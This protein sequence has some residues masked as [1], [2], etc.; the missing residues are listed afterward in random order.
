MY[1]ACSVT[2]SGVG[3]FY[4]I[5]F[6]QL[7]C[8]CCLFIETSKLLTIFSQ[9][10]ESRLGSAA[11][12]ALNLCRFFTCRLKMGRLFLFFFLLW[13]AYL[14]MT[15]SPIW[16]TLDQG[17]W[18]VTIRCFHCTFSTITDST[19]PQHSKADLVTVQSHWL[20]KSF[21]LLNEVCVYDRVPISPNVDYLILKSANILLYC[22]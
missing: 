7:H 4:F 11:K 22:V 18:W 3:P 16:V 8:R 2:F 19:R 13:V 15:E 17:V 1:S 6:S 21:S 12:A 5:M 10:D 20:R 9:L 14:G